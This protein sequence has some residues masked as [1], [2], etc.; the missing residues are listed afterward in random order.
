MSVYPKN[1]LTDMPDTVID[2]QCFWLSSFGNE[3][4]DK[5][6]EA[7]KQILQRNDVRLVRADEIRSSGQIIEQ[8]I[9]EIKQSKIVIADITNLNA[10]VLY[11]IGITHVT[12]DENHVL[13][14]SSDQ[15][16]SLPFDLK[17]LRVFGYNKDH[18]GTVNMICDLILKHISA[19]R[20][21]IAG[22][23]VFGFESAIEAELAAEQDVWVTI[24]NIFGGPWASTVAKNL[25]RGI[26]FVYV[27]PN[28]KD[29][30]ETTNIVKSEL[31]R[32]IKD[33]H[34]HPKTILEHLILIQQDSVSPM[35]FFVIDPNEKDKTRGFVTIRD[36][37]AE[38][39][40]SFVTLTNTQLERVIE[41]F[42]KIINIYKTNPHSSSEY[43]FWVKEFN[44]GDFFN[45]S[46]HQ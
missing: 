40:F 1:L 33:Y 18:P 12:K 35:E 15:L 10:N 5:L 38:N 3:Y 20:P 30:P 7:C 25:N 6:Y 28:L 19:D 23:R 26:N 17:H 21:D 39:S 24:H 34:V 2:N 11:E 36:E 44:L 22:N 41:W 31:R 8:I 16:N 43:P 42:T 27:F 32:I 4:G 46:L 45:E 29:N 37:T 13:L 9:R 14:I